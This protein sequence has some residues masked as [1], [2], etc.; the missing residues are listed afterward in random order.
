[1][2]RN[3]QAVMLEL[4]QDTFKPLIRAE[5][6]L[7]RTRNTFMVASLMDDG[8]CAFVDTSRLTQTEIEP[9]FTA[10]IQLGY[11]FPRCEVRPYRPLALI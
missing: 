7:L 2:I 5:I 11:A 4:E 3:F 1:M 9:L 6:A 10:P 8:T